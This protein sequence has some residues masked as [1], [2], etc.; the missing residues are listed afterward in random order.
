ML[1]SFIIGFS[2]EC[3]FPEI[4]EKL[5]KDYVI[6]VC[7]WVVTKNR[8]TIDLMD[9][10]H[11]KE[12]LKK[13]I[14]HRVP[15]K[16]YSDLYKYFFE[17]CYVNSRT[18][19]SHK[20]NN[21]LRGNIHEDV[22]EFNK[23]LY[24]I[25]SIFIEKR[26]ELVLF[27][28]IPHDGAEI[29]L[30][31][32]AK[33]MNIETV[34]LANLPHF[35]GRTMIFKDEQDYGNFHNNPK[36]SDVEKKFELD[37][38]DF[39]DGIFYMKNIFG[40]QQKLLHLNEMLKKIRIRYT[41]KLFF[42]FLTSKSSL[43]KT[44]LKL[45]NILQQYYHCLEYKNNIESMVSKPDYS[46]R[47]IYFA[48]HLDPEIPTMPI[49]ANEYTD[50]LLAI[51]EL[52]QKIPQNIMIYVKENPKQTDIFRPQSFFDRIKK[53]ENVKLVNDNTYKLIDGSCFVAT[54]S[55]TVGWEAI[56]SGK[57]VVLF[58]KSWYQNFSGA[59]LFNK[60][61]NFDEVLNYKIDKK[62]LNSSLKKFL[63]KTSRGMIYFDFSNKAIKITDIY[64]EYN[65]SKNI[66]YLAN[67][68][69]K[70]IGTQK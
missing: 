24:L 60:N 15:K 44:Q 12:F 54:I 47:Y 34:I 68:L 22:H 56:I 4:I 6:K 32:I 69:K 14:K 53:L 36:L 30:Y 50:Q 21:R 58:G 8:G 19:L 33:A 67:S 49:L 41:I 64:P 26:I 31:R 1:N 7:E 27:Q 57:N 18:F 10:Y 48:L 46:K 13:E 3:S 59:F 63:E 70:I 35:W 38:K 62:T 61:F 39:K 9:F 20:F 51:E 2:E 28:E 25:Y 37:L 11:G 16:L 43:N 66:E 17:F 42:R 23:F 40:Y 45:T 29:I 5:E 65:R 55:G 52:R